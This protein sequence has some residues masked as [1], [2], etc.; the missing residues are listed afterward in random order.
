[1]LVIPWIDSEIRRL[2]SSLNASFRHETFESI[3]KLTKTG[4]GRRE[5]MRK[6][7]YRLCAEALLESWVADGAEEECFVESFCEWAICNSKQ[8]SRS[9]R[10]EWPYKVDEVELFLEEFLGGKE[11]DLS[12]TV[13]VGGFCGI[14]LIAPV[15]KS[16]TEKVA[17]E[18]DPDLDLEKLTR[19]HRFLKHLLFCEDPKG[20]KEDLTYPEWMMADG[21][22]WIMSGGLFDSWSRFKRQARLQKE[23]EKAYE[24]FQK[25]VEQTKIMK[26]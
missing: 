18:Q 9:S 10:Y 3:P 12:T 15:F 25:A 5:G 11:F 21:P 4:R 14:K 19:L 13:V 20:W 1:L 23:F 17:A 26:E 8:E 22:E 2:G 6:R 24:E 16:F 7:D